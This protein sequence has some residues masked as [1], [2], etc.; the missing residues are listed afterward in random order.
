MRVIL[1]RVS[2]A[3]VTVENK[4]VA[5]IG[6]GLLIL[7]GAACGDTD[8]D[9]KFLA[10]KCVNLRIFE[11]EHGKMNLSA[12]QVGA[13][14]L[15]ISQFTLYADAEKG[16]RPSFTPALEP[17]AASEL[18]A[19]FIHFVRESKLVVE[20]GIFGEKMS[21]ELVNSGPVTLILDSK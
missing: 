6:K 3:E 13:E 7:M 15:V 14:L 21:V 4:T 16:R 19:R 12:L 17:K 2:R 9:A 5:K 10:D 1:Q 20:Q 8:E 11:D 18:Y